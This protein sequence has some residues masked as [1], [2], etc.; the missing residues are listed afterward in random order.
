MAKFRTVKP[1]RKAAPSDFHNLVRYIIE[2]LRY[3]YAGILANASITMEV[4]EISGGEETQHTLTPLLPV[5]EEGS[6]KD[7]GEIPCNLGGGPLMIRCKYGNILKNPSNAIYYKCNMESSG[8]ELRINGRAIEH[9]MFDRVW[10][11]AIHPSQNRFLVQVDLITDNPAALPATK[12][13]K[14]SFC[15][16][17]PRLKNLL[18]W[19]ASYVPA[20]AKDVDSVELRYVK[21]LTAKR[22]KDPTALR[23]SREEP[24]FQKIGLKAKVD[25]F[26]GYIDR[27][28]IYEAKAGKTKALDLYQLR[29]YVDGCALDNK[30]VDEA[31]LIAKRHSAEVKELRDILNTLTAPDGRPYNFR[32]ATWDEEGI[33]IRQS[34]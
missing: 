26:V 25:L 22:E 10:G 18:S 13:T 8:V 2:E 30:P 23:V 12:N 32:L 16:A 4:W 15:E 17:D 34:A 9:G 7:Y 11:E 24:V 20:P 19:I 33:V 5:W 3:V 31:V 27:V 14:T 1:D 6:V 21:E 28:T 29:M